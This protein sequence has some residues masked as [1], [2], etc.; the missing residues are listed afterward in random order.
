M[1]KENLVHQIIQLQRKADRARRQY[2]LDIWMSL[3]LTMA[4]LRSLFFINA[5]VNTTSGK[6]ATVQKVTPTNITGIVDRLVKQGLVSRT[7]DA[8]DRR[9]LSLSTTAK[10]EE[11]V[12]KLRSRRTVYLSGVLN[13]MNEDELTQMAQGLSGFIKAAEEQEA[14]IRIGNNN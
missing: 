2:E 8:Q 4:Q 11:L 7:E 1:S 9:S 13:R 12:T 14:E 3:P 6:L 10:G 5:Q